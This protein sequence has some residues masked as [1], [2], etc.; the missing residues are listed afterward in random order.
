MAITLDISDSGREGCAVST[1]TV[2]AEPKDWQRAT[3]TAVQEMRRLQRHGLT[4]GELDRYRQAILLDSAQLAQ[5]ANKVPSLD[6]LNFV[7]ES[8]A[9]GSTVMGHT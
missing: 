8:L 2:S 7:M 5:Q 9:C 4:Q 6:T 1:L 3:A